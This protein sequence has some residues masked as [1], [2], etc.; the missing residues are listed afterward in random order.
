MARALCELQWE[1]QHPLSS[2]PPA[3]TDQ[4]IPKTPAGKESKKKRGVKKCSKKLTNKFLQVDTALKE[5]PDTNKSYDSQ[6]CF[7]VASYVTHPCEPCQTSNEVVSVM[8]SSDGFETCS[9]NRIGNFPS[10]KEL[11][12]LDETLLA[13]RCNLGYRAGRILKFAQHVVEGKIQ[14][15]ALEEACRRIPNMSSYD[16]LLEQLKEINGFGP[17]TCANVL[18]CMGFYHIIPTDSET[19]RHL[20]QVCCVVSPPHITAGR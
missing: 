17:F 10:P 16:E 12:S 1:L 11:A 4:F 15:R 5:V 7:Q 13:N 6:D 8:S 2:V 14:L 19:I 9:R 20:K 3:K 18:M